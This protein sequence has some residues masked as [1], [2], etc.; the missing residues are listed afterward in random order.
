M[1]IGPLISLQWTRV[2]LSKKQQQFLSEVLNSNSF[3]G[4]MMTYKSNREPDRI[5]TMWP[6]K[7][8][9]DATIVASEL[10]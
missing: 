9:V 6:L 10:Y 2:T 1:L 7:H 8:D 5:M 4:Q 3:E